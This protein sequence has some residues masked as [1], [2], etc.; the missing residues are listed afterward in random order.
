MKEELDRAES[1]K[2]L[3]HAADDLRGVT[4]IENKKDPAV[5][6]WEKAKAT[7]PKKHKKAFYQKAYEESKKD[8]EW[9]KQKTYEK[10][11]EKEIRP[12]TQIIYFWLGEGVVKEH[13]LLKE[14]E[15]IK[16]R[17]IS[18]KELKKEVVQNIEVPEMVD[19]DYSEIKDLHVSKYGGA[20]TPYKDGFLIVRDDNPKSYQYF[21]LSDYVGNPKVGSKMFFHALLMKNNVHYYLRADDVEK[22]KDHKDNLNLYFVYKRAYKNKAFKITLKNNKSFSHIFDLFEKDKSIVEKEKLVLDIISVLPPSL[23]INYMESLGLLE[24]YETFQEMEKKGVSTEEREGLHQQDLNISKERILKAGYDFLLIS[25]FIGLATRLKSVLSDE[26]NNLQE[27]ALANSILENFTNVN[28]KDTKA[29]TK[30]LL[31]VIEQ[32]SIKEKEFREVEETFILARRIVKKVDRFDLKE[33]TQNIFD[34]VVT[35]RHTKEGTSLPITGKVNVEKATEI[36]CFYYWNFINFFNLINGCLA[37]DDFPLLLDDGKVFNENMFYKHVHEAKMAVGQSPFRTPNENL[38]LDSETK[39]QISEIL[40]E[41][42]DQTTGLLIP[43]NACVEL[44]DDPM[45]KYVRFIEYEKYIAIFVHDQKDRFLSELYVKGEKEFRYWMF[46]TGQV[47]D[48]KIAE[49]SKLI[50]LKIAACIRD[51]KILIERDSTMQVR[52]RPMIPQGVKTNKKRW[53]YLPR[54]TYKHSE[55]REQRS[56]E[57]VFFSESRKF[58]GDRRAHRRKL[59]SGMKASK[60]QMILARDV[61]FYVPE[62]YTFVRKTL[63]GK[64]KMSQREIKYR[65]TSLNGLFYASDAEVKKVKEIHELSPAGFEEYSEK[66][67]AGLGWEVRKRN[68]YDG[69][70]DIRALRDTKEGVEQLVA[71]CKHWKK[72]IGPDVLRELVGSATDEESEYKKVLMV[73][74]SS[75]FTVGAVD[76]AD[77]NDIILVD[78]DELLESKT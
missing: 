20:L 21:Q 74:T 10:L 32:C 29:L 48:S 27:G 57:K 8:K 54:V 37:R 67:V 55:T 5:K 70:I 28:P 3:Q 41:A 69:G 2:I 50:Y 56:R 42:M 78:G 6:K 24:R 16:G 22:V 40:T 62:G 4:D 53:I 35:Y 18:E 60:T 61:N 71:Q 31:E 72:P 46:N 51:W 25:K 13:K 64:I 75:K 59:P 30:A 11:F 1:F 7:V 45:L 43:Y 36:D 9:Q 17:I 12:E 66:Y 47:F 65:N 77:R 38:D 76:Y 19:I 23:I 44:K 33:L 52:P 49:S 26:R 15:A 39:S 63:W 68:N 58:S 73:I 14:K 34:L